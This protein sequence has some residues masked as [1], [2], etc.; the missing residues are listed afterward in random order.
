MNMH[1]PEAFRVF[2]A[3]V[4]KIESQMQEAF[5][6]ENARHERAMMGIQREAVEARAD[7][8]RRY[9]QAYASREVFDTLPV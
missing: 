8:Q 9:R 3:E 2:T 5:R 6:S 7:A 4:V 1:D